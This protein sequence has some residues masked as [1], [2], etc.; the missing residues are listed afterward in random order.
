MDLGGFE[1]R[2]REGLLVLRAVPSNQTRQFGIDALPLIT[3]QADKRDCGNVSFSADMMRIM[4]TAGYKV[5]LE[6]VSM[7]RST[8]G[9][10]LIGKADKSSSA[11]LTPFYICV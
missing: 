1:E 3:E 6:H 11:Q 4:R 2:D 8:Q 10:G 5:I 9:L 7:R